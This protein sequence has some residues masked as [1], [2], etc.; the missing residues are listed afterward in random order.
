MRAILFILLAVSS[1]L[2]SEVSKLYNLYQQGQYDSV[3]EQGIRILKT[4]KHDEQFISVYAFACLNADKIDRLALP[5]IMLKST[6]G[7]RKNA[8]FFSTILLQK[9]LLLTALE[10]NKDIHS[11][12]LPSTDYILSKVFDLYARGLYKKKQHTYI[13][14]DEN[15]NRRIYKLRFYPDDKKP[16]IIIDEYYD[17]IVTK[18]HIYY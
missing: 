11:L 7:A 4:H 8:A 16:K 17:T 9:N 1:A 14:A 3:C 10:N 5:I 15:D 6:N 13:L 12:S 18:Q 2:S